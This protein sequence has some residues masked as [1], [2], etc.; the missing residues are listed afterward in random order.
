[1]ALRVKTKWH[2]SENKSLEDIASVLAFTTWKVG[3]QA[4]DHL[5]DEDFTFESTQDRFAVLGEVLIFLVQIVDRW[6]HEEWKD[7]AERGQLVTALVMR[8]A[9]TWHENQNDWVVAG[10]YREPFIVLFNERA[11]EYAEFSCSQQEGPGYPFR[12]YLGA[13]VLAVMGEKSI[14]RW[15]I[16]QVMDIE[17]PEAL[18]TLQRG[19]RGLFAKQNTDIPAV[20]HRQTGT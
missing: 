14:N 3:V 15:V 16:D 11:Q 8:L 10:E 13:K 18:K 19:F 9:S 20:G 4:V 1:M 7:D 17:V 12:R 2:K 5:G 6:I